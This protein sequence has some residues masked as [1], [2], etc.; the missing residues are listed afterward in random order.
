M[1]KFEG[2]F[3]VINRTAFNR[4][5]KQSEPDAVQH[6]K[7]LIKKSHRDGHYCRREPATELLVVEIKKVVRLAGPPIEVVDPVIEED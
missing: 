4:T 2:K 6:A 7:S 1:D 5:F 3:C